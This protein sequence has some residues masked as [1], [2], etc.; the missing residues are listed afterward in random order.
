EAVTT[1]CLDGAGDLVTVVRVGDRAGALSDDGHLL[2]KEQ[3]GPTAHVLVLRADAG[4]PSNGG[5]V[6]CHDFL[7]KAG[8]PLP[9]RPRIEARRGQSGP[10][11]VLFQPPEGKSAVNRISPL[12]ASTTLTERRSIDSPSNC[13]DVSMKSTASVIRTPI[14]R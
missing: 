11:N 8:A 12:G 6:N 9:L 5:C 7:L 4:N 1:T 3:R 10:V 14:T 13:C 2:R